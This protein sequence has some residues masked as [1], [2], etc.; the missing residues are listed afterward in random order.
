MDETRKYAPGSTNTQEPQDLAKKRGQPST[1]W[2][3]ILEGL[4]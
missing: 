1:S 4:N 2:G 3:H